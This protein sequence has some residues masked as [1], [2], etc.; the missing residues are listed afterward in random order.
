[1][2]LIKIKKNFNTVSKNMRYRNFFEIII[3][4]NVLILHFFFGDAAFN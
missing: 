1:M 3:M 2:W 4:Q